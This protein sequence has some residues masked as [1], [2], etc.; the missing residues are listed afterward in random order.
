MAKQDQEV[1]LEQ[2]EGRDNTHIVPRRER[3]K[4]K[5]GCTLSAL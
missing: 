3:G 5:K 2:H 4:V 1:I